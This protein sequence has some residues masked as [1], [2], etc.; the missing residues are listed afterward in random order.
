MYTRTNYIALEHFAGLPDIEK[1]RYLTFL[2]TLAPSSHNTQPWLFKCAGQTIELWAN[3]TRKLAASDPTGREFY[4]SLGAALAN[5]IIASD[6]LGLNYQYNLKPQPASSDIPIAV[7]SFTNLTPSRYDAI[8]LKA[9]LTRR[10]NR[11][12]Y[13][14]RPIAEQTLQKIIDIAGQDVRADAIVDAKQKQIAQTIAEQA[15]TDAFKDKAFIDELSRWIKPSLK[16]YTD[17]M[18]GYNI[19]I[20]WVFS[21]F[22]PWAIKHL[23]LGG[24]QS[25]MAGDMLYASQAFM[26]LSTPEDNAAAWLRCGDIFEK[27]AVE[28]EI[29][30]LRLAL[31]AA[32]IEIGNHFRR[33]QQLLNINERPQLF[34][35]LGYCEK[36]PPFAPRLPLT[37]I[38]F[39]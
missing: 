33:L 15:T 27:M 28:T 12:K 32:P 36:I 31:L 9:I 37:Q 5:V 20:P 38:I 35:R 29:Q 14:N 26:V 39:N 1:L 30:N 10:C 6:A 3:W 8:R 19:G 23:P 21:F 13:D 7:V 34:F 2:A 11:F 17:G 22:M 24:S 25:K 16:K 18:P 4:I